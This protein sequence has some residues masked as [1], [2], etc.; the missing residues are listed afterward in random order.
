MNST[1]RSVHRVL[2][3]RCRF[4]LT[5]GDGTKWV[6]ELGVGDGSS[7]GDSMKMV[8]VTGGCSVM[9]CIWKQSPGNL[10]CSAARRSRRVRGEA[11]RS[12]K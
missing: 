12:S 2:L 10:R 8:G 1:G 4:G 6:A 7:A 5:N 11:F 3:L 9:T